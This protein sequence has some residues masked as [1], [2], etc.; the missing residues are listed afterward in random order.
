MHNI[1]V[2]EHPDHVI[3]VYYFSPDCEQEKIGTMMR[4]G[5]LWF[6]KLGMTIPEG[7]DIDEELLGMCCSRPLMPLWH[8]HNQS[9]YF[10][11][12]DHA[13]QLLAAGS[14]YSWMSGRREYGARV[15][16]RFGRVLAELV[17]LPYDHWR[18]PPDRIT[19][20]LYI[21]ETMIGPLCAL[22]VDPE[23]L[24]YADCDWRECLGSAQ[25]NIVEKGIVDVRLDDAFRLVR[26]CSSPMLLVSH[27]VPPLY[28][29]RDWLER[30]VAA[31]RARSSGKC[32]NPTIN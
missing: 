25:A 21:Q 14:E 19:V 16:L 2:I 30:E 22:S 9:Q 29:P 10:M 3:T 15:S 8:F 4:E 7:E 18:S 1:Y 32:R 27:C 28:I 11:A 24:A 17:C 26:K 12:L 20:P 13:E 31:F 6:E 23:D 5:I